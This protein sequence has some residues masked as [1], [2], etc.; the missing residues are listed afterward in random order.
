MTQFILWGLTASPYQLKMQSLLDYAGHSWERW[1]DQAGRWS[2]LTMA[3]RLQSA[4]RRGAVRRFPAMSAQFDE[5]PAVP[6][7][8][9]DDDVFYYDSSA[10]AHHLDARQQLD[11][12]PLMPR[13]SRMTFVCEFIDEEF[14]EL[15]L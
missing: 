14:D 7:Y 2:A 8:T 6:F 3:V 9:Q 11:N 4:K 13:D 10:L 15:G 12:P 5:Y 1:P